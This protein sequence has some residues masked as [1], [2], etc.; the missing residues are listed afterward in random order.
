MP[1]RRFGSLRST[2]QVRRASK[3]NGYAVFGHCLNAPPAPPPPGGDSDCKESVATFRKAVADMHGMVDAA[4]VDVPLDQAEEV[5][6]NL[7]VELGHHFE[8]SR[9][10]STGYSFGTEEIPGQVLLFLFSFGSALPICLPSSSSPLHS[11][12]PFPS[13]LE[14]WGKPHEAAQ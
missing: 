2:A 8:T 1:R 9:A 6:Y 7:T 4:L 5:G 14:V 10:P 3:M 13:G 11:C 12:A